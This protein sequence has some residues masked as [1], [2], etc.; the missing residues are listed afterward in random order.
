MSGFECVDFHGFWCVIS[1]HSNAD[2][3][4]NIQFLT[5]GDAD[6][7]RHIRS[8]IHPINELVWQDRSSATSISSRKYIIYL[9]HNRWGTISNLFGSMNPAQQRDRKCWCYPDASKVINIIWHREKSRSE[10][11]SIWCS[12]RVAFLAAVQSSTIA[13]DLKK[14]IVW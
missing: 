10:N 6:S 9:H 3:G 11:L 12:M 13:H 8:S 1:H 4:A 5:E 2:S 14:T 7:S